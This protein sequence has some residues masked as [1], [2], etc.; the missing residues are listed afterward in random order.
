M[1]RKLHFMLLWCENDIVCVC[2]CARALE[3]YGA[4]CTAWR[5]GVAHAFAQVMQ[6]AGSSTMSKAPILESLAIETFDDMKERPAC[7]NRVHCIQSGAKTTAQN[8]TDE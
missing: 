7:P 4:C 6:L 2:V 1:E 5:V 3:W 8:H